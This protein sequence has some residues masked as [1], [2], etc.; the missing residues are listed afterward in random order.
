[1]MTPNQTDSTLDP[2]ISPPLFAATL[3][4]YR[5][6]SEKG[7]H[8]LVLFTACLA[9]IPGTIFY[10]SGAWPIVGFLGLDV[11]ALYWALRASMFETRRRENVTLWRDRLEID[12]ISPMGKCRSHAFNPFWVRF[13]IE[14]DHD[15]NVTRL[16]LAM[17][18]KTLEIARFLGPD[19]KAG[20][21]KAFSEALHRAR[22]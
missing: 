11:L 22:G 16:T 9:L 20:F 6:L 19:E 17:R 10:M 4:P 1:M 3:S 13:G 12:Q 8:Y 18:Q 14:R 5:S 2:A 21:A 7:L 15:D